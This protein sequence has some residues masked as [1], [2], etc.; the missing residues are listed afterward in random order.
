MRVWG[1]FFRDLLLLAWRATEALLN[2]HFVAVLVLILIVYMLMQ[3]GIVHCDV[4]VSDGC[5]N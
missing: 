1:L 4:N 5:L 2:S 3:A